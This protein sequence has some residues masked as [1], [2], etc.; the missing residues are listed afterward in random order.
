MANSWLD[1]AVSVLAFGFGFCANRAGTCLVMA[2]RELHR[3]RP[4]RMLFGFFVASSAAGLVAVPLV[5]S[6]WIPAALAP[7]TGVTVLLLAGAVVF[8]LGA[9]ING[10]CLLGSLVRLGNG[11]VHLLALPIGLAAGFLAV[12]EVGGGPD[13]TWPSLLS[14][15]AAEGMAALGGFGLMLALGSGFLSR[16]HGARARRGQALAIS[17]A[18]LGA[19]GGLLY[20]L[21]SAWTLGDLVQSGLPLQTRPAG[22][23]ALV[24]VAAALGGSLTAAVQ[25]GKMRLRPPAVKSVARTAIGGALMGAGA[26]LI[27]GGN[28]DILL[29]AVPTLS[30]GGFAAFVAMLVTILVALALQARLRPSAPAGI[31]TGQ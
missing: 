9:L 25:A 6:G 22:G 4:P 3:G 16:G 13:R 15:P 30:P 7:S 2:A 27:P 5:W 31:S 20:A 11:E 17:M 28:D 18:A 14:V 26:G 24:A 10:T 1:I 21:S 19:T 12:D 8:G 23:S 29:A